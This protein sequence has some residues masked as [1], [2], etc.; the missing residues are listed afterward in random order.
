MEVKIPWGF[1]LIA[2]VI[3]LTYMNN[4]AK[5]RKIER[6]QRMRDAQEQIIERLREQNGKP[7]E[8]NEV[9]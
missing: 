2:I 4:K 9:D 6:R 3:A 1:F 5:N 8:I 7:N